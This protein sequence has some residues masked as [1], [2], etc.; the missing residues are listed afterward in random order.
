[1]HLQKKQMKKKN[2]Y[3]MKNQKASTMR[4]LKM[5]KEDYNADVT[6]ASEQETQLAAHHRS[7][8]EAP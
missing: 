6:E 8:R 1:M 7:N 5:G 4:H 3:S 2:A